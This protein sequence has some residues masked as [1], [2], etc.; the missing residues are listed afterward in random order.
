[1]QSKLSRIYLNDHRAG[2]VAG[3]SLAKRT[4]ANNKETELGAFLS[5]LVNEVEEDLRS[6]EGF[7]R[8]LQVP[9]NA[10]KGGAGWL[11][12]KL[13]RVKLNGQLRGY[14]P[15]SRLLELEGLSLAVEGKKRLWLSLRH[16]GE[17]DPRLD[18]QELDRLI[19]RAD[20][21]LTDL[22]GWRRQAAAAA[23][24]H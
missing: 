13:G 7:M 1:M 10:L 11:A 14:S 21:Q 3:V 12:E 4:L 19:Q 24:R 15:L 8:V 20:R 23:L 17:Q 9:S 16:I 22:E 5:D 18:P 2:A 6:L